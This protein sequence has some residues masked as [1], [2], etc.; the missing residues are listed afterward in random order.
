MPFN[1]MD[2]SDDACKYMFTVDQTIRMQTALN[3]CPNRY[4][5]GTHNICIPTPTPASTASASASFNMM[6]NACVNI[7]FMPF[8]T[9]SGYPNPTYLWTSSPAA[10]F[11]PANNVANPQITFGTAGTYTL[12]LVAT[13]SLSSSTYTM[14]VTTSFSCTQQQVCLDTL[15]MIRN[16]DTLTVYNA[17]VNPQVALCMSG[18]NLGFLTG[19]NCFKDKEFAQYF[20]PSTYTSIPY[21][22][23]NSAIVLFDSAGTKGSGQI[24]C[25]VVG[26]N[27]STGPVATLGTPRA[28]TYATILATTKTT[29]ISYMGKQG[30]VVPNRKIIPYR[31]DFAQPVVITTP[32]S[33]FFVSVV[34][35]PYT[36]V[37]DSV[38]IFS[39]TKTFSGSDSSAWFMSTNGTWRTFRY[40]RGAKIQLAI[41]PQ[42]TCSPLQVGVKEV[43]GVLASNISIMPNPS[44][45]VFSVIFTLPQM[46]ESLTMNIYNAFGQLISSETL[47]YVSNSA[48]DIDLSSKP[49][50]IY[51]T[52]ITN[53]SEKVV[54]KLVLT[55]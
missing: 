55:R 31:F 45:G 47:G 29:S 48:F 41:M 42:I 51:F 13:N 15:R 36:A 18:S 34:A 6:S 26:G 2:M 10:I 40:N 20:P 37:Y 54:K 23:V 38:R 32:S 33:G 9:S 49:D 30:Y 24:V 12:Q 1:F 52:E 39:N 46:Q 44:N 7:P 3:T 22:Q 19:T 8:N 11:S 16:L 21:P 35:P 50:G 28:E 43:A 4:L 25:R 27:A 5:L 53:G 14:A 17:P